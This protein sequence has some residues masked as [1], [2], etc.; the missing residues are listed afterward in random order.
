MWD[1][2]PW[3]LLGFPGYLGSLHLFTSAL[4]DPVSGST[5]PHS[6]SSYGR[7]ASSFLNLKRNFKR[8]SLQSV[9]NLDILKFLFIFLY[10]SLVP[11]SGIFPDWFIAESKCTFLLLLY[12]CTVGWCWLQC[13]TPWWMFSDWGRILQCSHWWWYPRY[14]DFQ[15]LDDAVSSWFRIGSLGGKENAL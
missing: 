12:Y 15:G 4:K 13:L 8:N 14:Q 7:V 10:L 5:V 9:L 3:M 2:F 11:K 6:R 1:F